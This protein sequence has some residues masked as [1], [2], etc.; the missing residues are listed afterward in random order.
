MVFNNQNRESRI[1]I[2]KPSNFGMKQIILG[3]LFAAAPSLALGILFDIL[4]IGGFLL[5]AMIMAGRNNVSWFVFAY[6]FILLMFLLM[7]YYSPGLLMVNYYIKL[8]VS[9][10]KNNYQTTGYICQMAT[11]PRIHSG[12]R[13][14]L[15]DAD[16]IGVLSIQTD[17]IE[18][19]G[20]HSDIVIPLSDKVSIKLRNI[21][22]RGLWFIGRKVRVQFQESE[23]TFAVDIAERQCW[24]LFK[25]RG[26][27]KEMYETIERQLAE[28]KKK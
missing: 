27:A 18:F 10:T 20:D 19:K 17:R 1:N 24:T 21:G 28:F 3:N 13:G 2:T 9:K 22:W 23:K 8:L 11:L 14:F 12:F 16:D 4:V 25:S 15:E 5:A 26:L 7:I 6:L